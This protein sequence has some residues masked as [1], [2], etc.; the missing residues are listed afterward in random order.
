MFKM[1]F[2]ERQVFIFSRK[3][4]SPNQFINRRFN[5]LKTKPPQYPR[6]LGL[7][8]TKIEKRVFTDE[9]AFINL[10]KQ[11]IHIK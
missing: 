10:L 6:H 11:R 9:S 7:N 1:Y 3:L 4:K 8:I 5:F 2:L